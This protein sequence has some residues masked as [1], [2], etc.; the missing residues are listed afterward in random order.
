M[1]VF[2]PISLAE[3]QPWL[4]N[5]F[6]LQNI[7]SFESIARGIENTN[8]FVDTPDNHYVLTIFEKLT[9]EELPFYLGIMEHLA[10]AQLPCPNPIRNKAG[11]LFSSLKNKPTALVSRLA[12]KLNLTPES[13]HCAQVGHY[14]AKMHLSL[15]SF[16]PAPDNPRGPNWWSETAPLLYPFLS[17][18]ENNLLHSEIEFQAQFR[19]RL[20]PRGPIH[21]DLFRDNVLFQQDTLSGLLD[22]YFAGSDAWIYDLAIVANDW[23]VNLEGAIDP[24]KLRALLSQYHE[25]RPITPEEQKVWPIVLRSAA[26]RFW[27]S[28][29]YDHHLPRLGELITPH[30]P[31]WFHTILLQRRETPQLWPL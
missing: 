31:Q 28:R 15:A 30:D 24:D 9:A 27:V 12:G 5:N 10:Q 16:Q 21:A 2:T 20:L 8:Y 11:T 29:L 18:S 25:I 14:L 13:Q 19:A 3:L 6:G 23:C 4:K 22:F 7:I 1:A 26:L 17:P